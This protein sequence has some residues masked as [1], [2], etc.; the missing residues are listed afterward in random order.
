MGHP[1]MVGWATRPLG[2]VRRAP[3]AH[4][5]EM[6]SCFRRSII[7]S[8][9]MLR[10]TFVVVFM[11]GLALVET[12]GQSQAYY[13]SKQASLLPLLEL[14]DKAGISGSLEFSGACDSFNGPDFPEVHAP[15]ES[16]VRPLEGVREMFANHPD[17]RVMQDPG[18]KIR[19]MQVGVETDFLNVKIAH[20]PFETGR[21]PSRHPIYSANAAL[22]HILV[23]PEVTRFIKDHS[24]EEPAFL[25]TGT[26]PPSTPPLGMPYMPGAP[27]DDVTVSEAMDHIL[28]AFPGIWYYEDCP[29]TNNR[30]RSV[31]IGFYHLQQL[32]IGLTVQ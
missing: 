13:A 20:I 31:R 25:A 18:G 21:P 10:C 29:Q 6:W 11:F 9:S 27:L 28:K 19:V 16:T 32:G 1:K 26:L 14:L 17:W 15:A 5:S 23:A 8:I 12:Q 2:S 24:I 22:V 3:H 30:S 4:V 7:R